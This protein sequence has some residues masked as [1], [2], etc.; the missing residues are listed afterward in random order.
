V[1]GNWTLFS[2]AGKVDA[3]ILTNHTLIMIIEEKLGKSRSKAKGTWSIEGDKLNTVLNFEG[4]PK[5][6]N[7][8]AKILSVNDKSMKLKGEK[9]KNPTTLI[10]T[11]PPSNF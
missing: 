5:N 11:I 6:Y 1:I 7:I 4:G 3:Q 2:T 10:R 9:D 8:S